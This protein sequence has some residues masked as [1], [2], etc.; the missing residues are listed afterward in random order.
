M[1]S[2][3]INKKSKKKNCETNID[4]IPK[5]LFQHAA[6]MQT[7]EVCMLSLWFAFAESLQQVT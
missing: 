3:H 5:V 7:L 2:G 4:C 6:Y 1:P